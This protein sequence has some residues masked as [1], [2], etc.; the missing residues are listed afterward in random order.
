LRI[1]KQDSELYQATQLFA[2][3][4]PNEYWN[5]RLRMAA[6]AEADTSFWDDLQFEY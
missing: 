4:G 5:S 1:A 3:K 2:N 6:G